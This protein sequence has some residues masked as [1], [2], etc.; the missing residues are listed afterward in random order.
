MPLTPAPP[1]LSSAGGGSGPIGWDTISP[2]LQLKLF[3]WY[4]DWSLLNES[5]A[6]TS[7]W[8]SFLDAAPQSAIDNGLSDWMGVE[9]SPVALTGEGFR[10]LNYLAFS[11]ISLL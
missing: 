6:S 2:V 3:D 5:Y 4:G 7:E 10:V 8:I 11:R 9:P 1:T